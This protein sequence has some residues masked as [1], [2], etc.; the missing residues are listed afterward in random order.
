MNI[1]LFAGISRFNSQAWEFQ[2]LPIICIKRK[3]IFYKEAGHYVI[4]HWLML[5]V[6]VRIITKKLPLGGIPPKETPQA[7]N[8]GESV[9]TKADLKRIKRKRK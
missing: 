4:F 1:R 3:D 7:Y 5:Q 6:Y 8:K 2:I 9:M